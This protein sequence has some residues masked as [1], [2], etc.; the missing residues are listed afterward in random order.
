MPHRILVVEAHP[1]TGLRSVIQSAPDLTLCCEARTADAAF[2]LLE[3]SIPDLL[4][5]DV[6]L[7]GVDGIELTKQV[8]AAYPDFPILVVSAT[9]GDHDAV[10]AMQAG[11]HG[12]ISQ[13]STPEA[14][15]AAI[16]SVLMGHVVL[17]ESTRERLRTPPP[18]PEVALPVE[19]LSNRQLDV[20]RRIGQGMTTTEI[21]DHLGIS[22]KTVETHRINIKNKLN[23][24][25]ANALIR[26]AALWVESNGH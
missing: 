24:E 13:Q 4:I 7:P 9:N 26:R 5:T 14:T 11:A 20:L 8:R 2:P 15:L 12:C 6:S 3:T 10:R 19:S 18:Q 1:S 25:T 17:P 22:P 21:A 23:L 16:R